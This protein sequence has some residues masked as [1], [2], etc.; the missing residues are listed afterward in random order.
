[1]A[2]EVKVKEKKKR[3][4]EAEEED[5][6]PE[7]P[8][9]GDDKQEKKRQKQLKEDA[10]PS[11]QK[12]SVGRGQGENTQKPSATQMLRAKGGRSTTISVMLPASIID[13]CQS[14][15]LKA[16]LVGQIARALTIYGVNEVVLFEDRFD[17]AWSDDADNASRSMAFFARNLQ[18]LETPQYLRRQ[19][20]PV[21]KDL[22]HVGLLSP[23]DAPHHLRKYERLPY[24]DGAVLGKDKAPAPPEDAEGPGV[25]VNCGLDEPVWVSGQEIPS[26]VRVTVRFEEDSTGDSAASS[27]GGGRG[28]G[29]GRGGGS[30]GGPQPSRGVAVSPREPTTRMGIYWGFQTRIAT[31]LKAVFEECPYEGGYDLSIGTSERGE[32]LGLSGLPRFKHLMI[33]FGGLGGFEE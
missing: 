2:A 26:D 22:R 13:N 27:G 4:V 9:D 20:L 18:Y 8:E 15:E 17:T 28:G 19:L 6:A 31:T 30:K 11:S 7:A 29:K 33:G 23:L 12:T 10:R 25:W 3:K 21:H 16:V 14:F 24:R 32:S 1:M 5:E